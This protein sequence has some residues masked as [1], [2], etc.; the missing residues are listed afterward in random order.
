MESIRIL[1]T[2]SYLPK[3]VLTNYDLEKS[4][5]DT[6]NEWIVQR[7][8]VSER[9]I[10][11][12]GET[13]ADLGYQ[14]SLRALEMAGMGIEMETVSPDLPGQFGMAGR[15]GASKKK[16]VFQQ[17]NQAAGFLCLIFG[18]HVDGKANAHQ[19]DFGPLLQ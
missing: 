15:P 16:Q 9:R 2:G 5:L 3:T 6:T 13:T 14:A 18:P 10:A 4:G 8:G 12:A 19:G 11:E 17:V 7:T 1:G